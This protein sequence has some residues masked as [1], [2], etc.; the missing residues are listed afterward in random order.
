MTNL[1]K[2]HA[3]KRGK[4]VPVMDDPSGEYYNLYY[5]PVNTA[6]RFF[7]G[8]LTKF[9]HDDSEGK[10]AL[11]DEWVRINRYDLYGMFL[12]ELPNYNHLPWAWTYL[13]PGHSEYRDLIIWTEKS[14]NGYMIILGS[15][16][17][18]ILFDQ[19]EDLVAF[20][21]TWC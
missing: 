11:M 16:P 17:K 15:D 1:T 13:R 20:K 18:Y 4:L 9:I 6:Q 5:F 14:V 12:K 3:R 10:D 21:L 19:E 7:F 8:G 2:R